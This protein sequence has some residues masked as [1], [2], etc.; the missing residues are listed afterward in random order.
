MKNVCLT[1]L[2]I[3]AVLYLF[4]TVL[5][6]LIYTGYVDTMYVYYVYVYVYIH[7]FK[8]SWPDGISDAISVQ[9]CYV[10]V[11]SCPSLLPLS[12]FCLSR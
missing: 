2:I 8:Q 6:L 12:C 4:C 11:R 7:A 10:V 9:I 1:S 3:S 5:V